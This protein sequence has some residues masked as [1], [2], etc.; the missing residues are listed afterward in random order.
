MPMLSG[1]IIW[2][3]QPSMSAKT[4][5]NVLQLSYSMKQRGHIPI[6]NNETTRTLRKLQHNWTYL[7][8]Q[9]PQVQVNISASPY[10]MTRAPRQIRPDMCTL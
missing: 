8:Q 9:R 7:A 5:K 10:E 6:L 2:K 1:L 3:V 4:K